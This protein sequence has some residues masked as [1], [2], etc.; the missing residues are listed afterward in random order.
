MF[1]YV[2]MYIDNFHIYL[3]V[4]FARFVDSKRPISDRHDQHCRAS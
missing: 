2:Y 4:I 1:V 3:E